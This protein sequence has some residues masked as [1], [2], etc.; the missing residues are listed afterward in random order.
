MNKVLKPLLKTLS[1]N[2]FCTE[3]NVITNHCIDWRGKFKGTAELIFFPKNVK[4]VIKIIKFCYK[5]KI[6]V[7]PQ[8][9]NTSLVGGSVPRVNKGEIIINLSKLNKIREVDTISNTVTLEGGCILQDVNDKL[10]P[11]GLEMPISLG[12]KG[13]CQIG[14]NI[15]TNAGGLNVIKYGSIR[16][17]ILGIEAVLP[18]GEFHD[19]LKTIKKNN[20]GF[21]LKQLLIGSEGTLGIITAATLKIYKKPNERVVLILSTEKISGTL[22]AYKIITK[23]FGDLITAFELMNK[24]SVNLTRELDNKLKLPFS[25]NY[26]CL[27][28]LTNFLDIKNF[29]NFII[30]KFSEIKFKRM[31]IIIAKSE[32]ENKLFWRIREEIPLAEKLLK[33]VIQHDVS[34]P[35]NF[36][37]KF[38]EKSSS[39]LKK[40]DS[41][42]SIINF[43]HLGDNNLHFNIFI[44]KILDRKEYKKIQKDINRI[45]F[46][47]VMRFNGSISA[48][49]GIG[50][51]RRRELKK[52]KSADEIKKMI[53]IKKIF[54]PKGI[55]N[56]GKII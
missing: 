5:N 20:T 18:N 35:L 26:Y 23:N 37:D 54:D 52:F 47:N 43:G 2:E 25:G 16:S 3:Q 30:D 4:S 9:G 15:A 40:L 7:V 28:E 48:E 38:I 53:Q 34:L 13:S 31:K 49:H 1:K 36:I 42:I 29:N 6:S 21:D 33:N 55:M 19:D 8:G 12:S 14:G 41:K 46:S 10:E 50:Q 45:V 51:L 24:F 44:D 39:S 11:F 56:P 32:S 27:I 17:N 22:E